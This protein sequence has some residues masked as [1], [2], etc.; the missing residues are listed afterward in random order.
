MRR[1]PESEAGQRESEP[2]TVP[3]TRWTTEPAAGKA[4]CFGRGLALPA[5]ANVREPK[6]LA[7]KTWPSRRA[8][9]SIR[10]KIEAV[11][12]PRSKLSLPVEEIVKELN[13]ISRG[14]GAY[15]RRF[16]N[17]D[18]MTP[19]DRHV[20]LQVAHFVSKEAAPPGI[21]PGQI[22]RDET[23]WERLGLYA[24]CAPLAAGGRA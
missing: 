10:A 9:K 7:T 5:N 22:C 1:E 11:T 2:A 8:K 13:P 6:R 23:G 24:L 15:S 17:G 19:I 12:A 16:G 20:R 4:G 14:W 18:Q 21:A 3:V